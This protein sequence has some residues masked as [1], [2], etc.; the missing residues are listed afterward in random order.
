M[1]CSRKLTARALEKQ[2]LES[3]I[4]IERLHNECL[5]ASQRI[6]QLDAFARHAGGVLENMFVSYSLTPEKD[7][8]KRLVEQYRGLFPSVSG[9]LEF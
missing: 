9:T 7:E 3:R 1:P 2:V 4:R 5:A 8:L 6:D